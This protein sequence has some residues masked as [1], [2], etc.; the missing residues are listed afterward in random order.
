MFTTHKSRLL[1]ATLAAGLL[2]TAACTPGEQ[3]APWPV[4]A[5]RRPARSSSGTSSPTARRTRSP[6]SSRTSRPS[7][8]R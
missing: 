2:A 7:T 3:A 8:P 6:R 5:S 4:P 1:L